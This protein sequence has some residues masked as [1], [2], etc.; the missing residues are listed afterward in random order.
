MRRLSL[1]MLLC[2]LVGLACGQSAPSPAP[3]TGI[4]TRTAIDLPLEARPFYLGLVPT[5]LSLPAS[6]FDDLVAAYQETGQIAE[7]AMVWTDPAGIGAHDRLTQNRVITALRVYGLK[8]V[9]TLNFATLRQ[10]P[11]EGLKYVVD[12]P[13]GMNASLADPAFRARWVEEAQRIAAD[14]QPE[15]FSLGNE[16]NDYFYFHPEDWEA[17]LSLY[18]EARRAI[19]AASP[20]TKVFVVFS[21]NHLLENDQFAML[22]AFDERA[23]LIGL[24]TYPWRQYA[25]PADLPADYYAR[26]GDYIHIPIAFTEI[27]WPSSSEAGSSEEEQA[28]FLFRFL[29]L[30]KGLRLEMVNWLFLHEQS[31]GGL[32]ATISDPATGTIALKSADGRRKPVYEVWLALKALPLSLL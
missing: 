9:V 8:A 17:Y 3:A 32:A 21:L 24:T 2:L 18:D 27:G 16:I 5:P 26:L 29:D 1:F 13:P 23:D 6:T 28:A 15:Y 31:P 14:F 22:T 11:G 20:S 25:D 7:I 4:P 12:A 10:A 30:T 19:Q